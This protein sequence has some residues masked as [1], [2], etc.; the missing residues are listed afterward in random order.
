[1]YFASNSQ[2]NNA[3]RWADRSW[4]L[5][6]FLRNFGHVR[7]VTEVLG[8]KGGASKTSA[9]FHACF[10]GQARHSHILFIM[11]GRLPRWSCRGQCDVFRR[12][13]C[14]MW[15][16]L[17]KSDILFIGDIELWITKVTS[18]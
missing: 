12:H 8:P 16:V 17:P 3:S 7:L 6:F 14:S 18:K 1:M 4:S 11:N 5:K 2:W 13:T 10:L 15:G 9:S